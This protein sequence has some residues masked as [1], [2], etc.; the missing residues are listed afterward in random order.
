MFQCETTSRLQPSPGRPA[1]LVLSDWLRQRILAGELR[2]GDRLPSENDPD[3][4]HGLSR[5]TV[6]EALR[7]LQSDHLVITTRGVTGGTFVSAPRPERVA[8][9]LTTGLAF[10]AGTRTITIGELLDARGMLEVPAAALAAER[11]AEDDVSALAATIDDGRQATGDQVFA[12]N[13]RF[14]T[15]VLE[16]SGNRLLEI[17]ARPI[18]DVLRSQVSRSQVPASYWQAI[19]DDH[20]DVADAIEREDSAGAAEA[21]R[22]HIDRLR[23]TYSDL[24]APGDE[25][26]T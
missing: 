3:E 1:Y 19:H 21:M 10:L 12:T 18:F 26:T 22:S 20:A 15:T 4:W 11:R 16:M 23:V 17:M 14:H 5:S 25:A 24:I 7:N 6:R 8:G 2:P 9:S 13:R